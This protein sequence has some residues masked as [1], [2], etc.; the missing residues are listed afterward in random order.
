MIR[1]MIWLVEVVRT[2][3]LKVVQRVGVVNYEKP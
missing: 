1:L 2:P 3:A